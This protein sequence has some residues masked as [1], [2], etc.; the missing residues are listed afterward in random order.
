MHVERK[1][2][3]D[4]IREGDVVIAVG[5]SLLTGLDEDT[6]EAALPFCTLHCLSV[7]PYTN[8]RWCQ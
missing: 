4:D 8:E 6:V 5:G 7:K 1:P 3:Q 2:G